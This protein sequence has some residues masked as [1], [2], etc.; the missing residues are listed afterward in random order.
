MKK[1]KNYVA[2]FYVLSVFFVIPI[3]NKGTY[4]NISVHKTDAY[5]FLC[6]VTLILY[7]ITSVIEDLQKI[8]DES[9]RKRTFSE[10][11]IAMAVF[12]GLV[13]IS[14]LISKSV[15]ESMYGVPGFGMGALAICLMILSFFFI[16]RYYFYNNWVM[17]IIVA[18]SVLP[19][20][21]AIM[22]RMGFDPLS[23]FSNGGDP[24][25][26]LY[27]S[28]F[29]NYGWYSEYMAVII[30]IAVYMVFMTKDKMERLLYGLYI[31]LVIFAIISCG[32]TMMLISAL[33]AVMFAFKR[34]FL[35]DRKIVDVKFVPWIVV[36]VML[37]YLVCVLLISRNGDLANGRGY[38]WKLSFDLYGSLPFDK[39]LIGV[40][41]NRFMY[42]LNEYF[43][44]HPE[45]MGEFNARFN[46]LALTS[47][48]SEYLD[49]LVCTGIMGLMAYLYVIFRVVERFLQT[50]LGKKDREIAFIA[51][52]SYMIYAFANFSMVCATPMFFIL[53]GMVAK[54]RR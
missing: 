30:P 28:T 26:G 50:G 53:M 39:K 20:I 32:T 38:I 35:P 25:N 6:G 48:H 44:A 46:G 13:L 42:A 18:S 12:G 33:I 5:L 31:V 37:V 49:Y 3:Y 2:L 47:A 36:G 17:H 15:K 41:P 9:L 1:Y 16:S 27:V 29:G 43:E 21:L 34:K 51:V 11:D 10:V 7:V 52:I 14:A 4:D 19:T 22:N 45:A 8:N 40:G 23:M 54:E 24:Q